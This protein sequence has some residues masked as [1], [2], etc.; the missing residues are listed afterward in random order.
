MRWYLKLQSKNTDLACAFQSI[1]KQIAQNHLKQ[2]YQDVE[3]T[4]ECKDT[5]TQ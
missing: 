2:Y 1:I 5:Q 4:Y 3:L